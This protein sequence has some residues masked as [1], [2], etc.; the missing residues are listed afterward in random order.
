MNQASMLSTANN[1]RK[2]TQFNQEALLQ[3]RIIND[4]A[5]LN[6]FDSLLRAKVTPE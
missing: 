5:E 6:R 1:N 4:Q 3:T 2:D